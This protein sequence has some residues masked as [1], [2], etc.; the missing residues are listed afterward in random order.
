MQL[1]DWIHDHACR[2]P[3]RS[4]IRF[5][6]RE[7][8]YGALARSIDRHVAALAAAGVGRGGCVAWLGLNS[9]EEIALLFACAR[10][11]AMFVPLNWRLAAPEHAKILADCP[12]DVLFVEAPFV[13][14]TRDIASA[15]RTRDVACRVDSMLAVCFAE[16]PAGWLG[17]EEFLARGDDA[18]PRGA[19]SGACDPLAPLLV[20]YTSGSTGTPKGVMLSQDALG[21]NALNSA[22]LQEITAEDRILNN[23]PLFHVGGLNNQ[24]T[25]AL[26]LGATVVLHPK[27]DVDTTFDAIERERITL[28]QLVPSQLTAMI[29]SPRWHSADFSSLR[30]ILTGSTIVA[31]PLIRAV[32]ERGVRMV[33]VYG[34]TETC[35]IATG[36]KACD[37]HRKIGSAGKPATHCE[38]RVLDEAG[39]E[40]APGATG[41]IVVRGRNVMS[42]YWN[43][44]AA[45][46]AVLV[47]GWF[48]SGDM[49][50]FDEEGYLYVDGRRKELIIS[51]GENIYP[52]EIENVL[53]ESPDIAEASVVGWPDER[54]G[55]IVV[56]MVVPRSDRRLTEAEV[57]GQIEG[58]IA[59]FKRP[60]RV[61]FAEDLPKSALGKVRREEVRRMVAELMSRQ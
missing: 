8:S 58:R 51:G 29:T 52:A 9:P 43:A 41:E 21:I 19:K 55:E 15:A 32:H 59:R 35:P 30:L 42:G 12:P 53:T 31:E 48:H 24:T 38:V 2:E 44:P 22:D 57:L 54:W 18:N 11:G 45:T 1:S 10:L 20:C 4:A 33:Q 17:Y 13:A 26:R 47:D 37:A 50:H 60:R 49:G 39:R 5:P 27:F 16:P 46:E 61:V 7:L 36:L 14:Q 25:P 56:A 3:G 28:A 40:A 34:A 6:G 23:L